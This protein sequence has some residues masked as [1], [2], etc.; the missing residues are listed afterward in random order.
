MKNLLILIVLFAVG[1]GGD[2]A[3]QK[4]TKAVEENLIG[5]WVDISDN[6]KAVITYFKDKTFSGDWPSESLGIAN[7]PQLINA[8]GTWSVEKQDKATK[9]KYVF[10]KA[11]YKN[12][13]FSGL[14]G[15]D[16]ILSINNEVVVFRTEQ[17]EPHVSTWTRQL[18]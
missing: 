18:P 11:S 14:V 4:K 17:P 16:T 3:D 15:V 6:K 2:N 5:T 13:I 10:Q 1:C 12:E 7:G 8:S 9:V